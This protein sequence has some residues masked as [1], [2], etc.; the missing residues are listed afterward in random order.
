M[1]GKKENIRTFEQKK[2]IAFL[3]VLLGIVF[4]TSGVS[5]AYFTAMATSNEQVVKSGTLELT[6]HTGKD[7]QAM[8]VIP[9]EEES[10][11][12][13][14]FTVENTGTLDAHYNISFMD[15]TLTK[16]E[17][18]TFSDNLK[19]ALYQADE[20]YTE[21][22]LVKTGSFSP[23]SGYLSG[24]NE[25]VIKTNMILAPKEKQS[26]LLK[27]WL[28]ETGKPQNEDQ[29]LALAMKVQ[30]D[31]LEKQ[32]A[33]SKVSTM[34]ERNSRYSSETFYQYKDSITKVVF[35]NRME[36]IETD[37]SWD[38]SENNN[39]N[40]MAYLVSN[41]EETDPTYTLYVQGNDVIYLSSGDCLFRAFNQLEVIEGVE[42]VNTSQVTNM[43]NMFY[44][45]SGLTSLDVSGFDTS[46]VT[47]MGSMFDGCSSLTSLDLSG[48]D[49][50]KVT[51][52]GWM[53]SDC[54][55]LT[56]LDVSNFNTS[57]VTYMG[58]MFDGCS[59][60]TS[61]DVSSFDTSQV[62][63]MG[64]MF[65]GCS[66]L[67]SLDVSGFDTS[68]VTYMRSMFYECSGLTSLDVSGFDTSQV[69]N[70]GHMFDGCS[71]LTS[72]DVSNFNTSKVT[73]MESMFYRCSSLT[74]LDVSSFDTSQV[75]DMGGM[76]YDCSG[77]TNL[78]LSSFDTSQVT[79]MGDMFSG[80]SSLTILDLSSFD[81]SQVTNMENMFYGCS[82]LTSLD[83]SGFDTSQV[84]DMG[85]MFYNC[86]SLTGLNLSS[87]DT[88]QVTDMSYMFDGCS[89]LTSLDF[90]KATFTSVT[91]YARMFRNV[92]S[93]IKITVKDAEA[94]SWIRERLNEEGYTGTVII[95]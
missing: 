59:G 91:N 80:C 84:T 92:Q 37:L 93:S 66:G 76:F 87:F 27:V 17:M 72:L 56:S 30:V 21:G 73:S 4:I 44:G 34:R 10:A 62:T 42:Y 5:Y 47:D 25:L 13:H 79:D 81:T 55:G 53:F 11:S 90:R 64:S 63:D 89:S 7:I 48:F 86:S 61:L 85:W 60:L 15:I 45:C 8:N 40:C 2:S 1:N 52:M 12:V 82:S 6:Y 41:G 9:T 95:A 88:S 58:R 3:I 24:D 31:T 50:S 38:V 35:Q 83:V 14:Q 67:T 20:D 51:D 18:D 49:T 19:W 54:S 29:G 43:E 33:T 22:S 26:Y 57:Q 39:G 68:Q 78:D 28:Q 70:M 77:L 65:S 23:T 71:S 94:Q 32:E 75:T 16:K 46:K 36:P 69:T 74:S